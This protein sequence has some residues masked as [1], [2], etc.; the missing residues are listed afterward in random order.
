[1]GQRFRGSDVV[2]EEGAEV[3]VPCLCGD[4][5]NRR[6]VDGGGCGVASAE[7]VPGD[8]DAIEAGLDGA[9]LHEPADRSWP[10]ALRRDEAGPIDA[11]EERARN[12]LTDPQPSVEGPDGICLPALPASDTDQ[13]PS[14]V[15]VGLGTADGGKEGRIMYY[16]G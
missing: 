7:R 6:T 9:R 5:V 1:M 12:R 15:L 14:A 11:R 16:V 4:P 10:D 13:L 8:R 3:A 2:V